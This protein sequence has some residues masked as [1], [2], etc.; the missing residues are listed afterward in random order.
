[1]KKKVPVLNSRSKLPIILQ[2]EMSE[3]GHACIAMIANFWGHHLDLYTLRKISRP[4]NRGINLLQIK[5]LLENLGFMIRGLKVSLEE[6]NKVKTPAI[7]HWDMNHFVVLKKIGKRS[8]T[9]HDP[10]LGIRQCSIEEV[11]NS[12]T[13]IALEIAKANDFQA[14]KNKSKLSL[15]DLVKT[16]KGINNYILFLILISLAIEFFSLLNPLFIQYVTDSVIISSNIGN[17]YVIAIAFSLLIFIQIFTEYIRGRM[18][19]Y[20]TMSLTE[21]LSA[22]LVKHLL[23]LPLDFFEKRHNGDIQSKCQSI[24]QI[25]RKISTDFINAVLDGLVIIINLF[26]MMIYCQLLASIVIFTLLVYLAIRY[27]TYNR[28]KRQTETSIYQH[29]KSSSIFLETLQSIVSIKS[30]LKE[31]VRFNIWRNSYINSLNADFKIAKI[32]N[33]YSMVSQLLFGMEHILVVSV[34]AQLILV[35]KFSIGMLM[36]FLSYR[37]LLVN[38]TS[39][40]IQNI[41]DYKLIS[42]Q[43]DRLSD[44]LFHEPEVIGTG[45]GVIEQTKGALTLK[46]IFFRYN[47][48]DRYVLKD[49]NLDVAAGEK[50]AI[51]GPSGCGKST[52]LKVMMGLLHK[53]EGEIFIDNLPI[54]DFGLKNYRDL[55]ASVMQEDSLI[56]GSIGDN[57]SFFDENVDR[58]R[59]YHVAKLA[60]IHEDICQLPMGYETLV[61]GMGLSLSS[62]QKQRILLARALYK[63]PKILFLDEATSHLDVVNEKSINSS[64]KSLKITQI[65][66]AHRIETI[67]MA[68]RVINLKNINHC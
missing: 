30:F 3:C 19:I 61:G 67:Q 59:V 42:I 15:Y 9:I 6:L 64:L 4:S 31:S 33:V 8:I 46:N 37:L 14:I 43:L 2:S 62:G 52:L 55:I 17:L 22:N 35:N 54:K 63:K 20:L 49:I 66:I 53:T 7:L 56:S 26:V 40:L 60:S 5:D 10:A 57:I 1:M 38:K 68:D 12:F 50:I 11:S 34:G 27:L 16:V 25:Q 58:E 28:V 21:N 45:S 29:A 18:V 32:N 24:D 51:I 65:V 23:K 39:S 13:G 47:Q 44:I 36:A 48:N 41:F